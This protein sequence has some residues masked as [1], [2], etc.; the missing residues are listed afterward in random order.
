MLPLTTKDHLANCPILDTG[1]SLFELL[2]RGN[3]LPTYNLLLWLL[4]APQEVVVEFILLK[5]LMYCK[6]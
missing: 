4:V 2:F 6:P 5:I 1:S 3:R